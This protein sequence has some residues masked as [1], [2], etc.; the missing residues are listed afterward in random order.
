MEPPEIKTIPQL[1]ARIRKVTKKGDFIYRGENKDHG[2][3]SSTLYRY[4]NAVFARGVME[5]ERKEIDIASVKIKLMSTLGLDI[6]Y[7]DLVEVIEENVYTQLSQRRDCLKQEGMKPL[8]KE[9]QEDWVLKEVQKYINFKSDDDVLGELQHY[10]GFTNLIDFS[11][12]IAVALFFACSGS[13]KSDGRLIFLR[14]DDK[15]IRLAVKNDNNRVI[16][17]KSVFV[18]RDDGYIDREEEG[19]EVIDIPK[20]LKLRV[21]NYVRDYFGVTAE[22]MYADLAGYIKHQERNRKAYTKFY[23]GV[24]CCEYGRFEE[25]IDYYEKAIGLMPN[26]PE[27]YNNIGTAYFDMGKMG[28]P[29]QNF[30]KAL[31]NYNQAIGLD[32]QDH[33]LYANCGNVYMLMYHYFSGRNEK[34]ANKCLTLGFHNYLKAINLSPDNVNS[35]ILLLDAKILVRD[36]KDIEKYIETAEKL[37]KQQENQAIINKLKEMR[38]QLKEE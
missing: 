27:A 24:V 5:K 3:I 33:E 1:M 11:N 26:F 7:D 14:A 16:S 13:P 6:N 2:K 19:L 10:G 25:G 38:G 34:R 4:V 32:P 18:Q 15:S 8:M 21:L 29:I 12:D 22:T 37:A 31:E 35:Y 28:R 30:K 23:A 36:Y 9:I 17:Q 20:G